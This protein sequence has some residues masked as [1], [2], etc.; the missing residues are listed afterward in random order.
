[1]A[2][3]S[4]SLIWQVEVQILTKPSRRCAPFR[5][6]SPVLF[7]ALPSDERHHL[8][9][10]LARRLEHSATAVRLSPSGRVRAAD[11]HSAVVSY[12]AIDA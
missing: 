4:A 6:P 3:L 10:L 12:N 7:A 2:S 11:A 1:M 5:G 9:A 8:L